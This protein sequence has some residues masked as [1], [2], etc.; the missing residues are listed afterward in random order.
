VTGFAPPEN[1]GTLTP[2]Q[3]DLIAMLRAMRE[4]ERDLFAAFEPGGQPL[5]GDGW[6]ARDVLAHLAAWR[7]IEARRLTG[8]PLA[9]DPPPGDPVDASNARLH[10]ERTEWTDA[11]VAVEAD[12]SVETLVDA[13]R[14]ST[15]EALCECDELAAGIGAN[16][17]NHAVGHLSDLSRATGDETRYSAFGVEVER[18]LRR[19]H[20]PPRDS[21]VMLYNL[22]CHSALT[23]RTDE[24]LRLLAAAFGRRADLRTIAADDPDL[25][26]IRGELASL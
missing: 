9:G 12:A 11:Q 10:A 7:A 17:I 24:A 8:V 20:L 6:S 2:L 16:G 21:G 13:I 25:A 1:D 23:G 3:S 18:I 19:G 5:D 26:S 22:A 15:T 14:A 4:A